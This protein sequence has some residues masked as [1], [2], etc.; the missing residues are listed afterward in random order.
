[1][2]PLVGRQKRLS[3]LARPTPEGG[4]DARILVVDDDP[5]NLFVLTEILESAGLPVMQAENG[6]EAVKLA[7]AH[8]PQIVLMDLSMPGMDGLE[9]AQRIF[10]GVAEGDN[11]PDIIAVSANV[12]TAHK[13]Q[14]RSMGFVDFFAKPLD[15]DTIVDNVKKYLK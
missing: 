3:M 6:F 7:A 4:L 11:A 13:E 8:S 1:M 15:F 10:D 9:T 14:C 12:T 2:S 5:T